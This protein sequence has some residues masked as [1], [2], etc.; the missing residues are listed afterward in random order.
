MATPTYTPIESYTVSGSSTTAITFGSGNTL[1][2]TYTDLVIIIQ[3]IQDSSYSARNM[4]IR[5]NGDTGSNYS[6]VQILNTSSGADANLGSAY[7]PLINSSSN[8]TSGVFATGIINVQNYASNNMYKTILCEGGSAAEFTSGGSNVG[9]YT[10]TNTALWRNTAPITQI[11]L[12]AS[13]TSGAGSGAN[14]LAGSTVTVYGISNAGDITPKATGGD[15]YSDSSYWYHVFPLS[16]NF[17]PNQSITAD[18]LMV[19]GGGS[20]SYHGPG[21]PYADTAGGGAGGLR[22]LTSQ[23]LTA[24]SYPVVIG[25]GG[26]GGSGISG[27][28]TTFN[29]LSAAGGGGGGIWVG[30]AGSAGGSG[31]GG[32]GSYS[33]I[34][35]RA[36][37]AGNTPSTSPSQGNNGG[38]GYDNNPTPAGGGG[39]GAGGVGAN[40]SSAVGGN[41]GIGYYDSFTNAIGALAGVGQ[42]SSGN[43][44]FAG[45][46]G[47]ATR[48]S[49]QGTGGLGGGTAGAGLD[50]SYGRS[51]NA[52]VNSGGGSG[53]G[54]YVG[55]GGS[56][57]LVVR[58]A[59]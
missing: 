10:G 21:V 28:A 30:G 54:S 9:V 18:V 1:P 55:N 52:L 59:K 4:A 13:N 49:T 42:L 29:S 8:T 11:T 6:S 50:N 37:G 20:G 53:G 35:T 47:G 3:G 48:G 12:Y 33:G 32:A 16:G 23:S 38:N 43:Y 40:A 58:Y 22:V 44:Y 51:A 45:G 5:F 56:G 17:V 26:A 25:A 14:W 46:G 24:Q 57:L 27:G 34:G 2:Q 7:G 19:G 36:G 39:G 15:V 41:G 31:G